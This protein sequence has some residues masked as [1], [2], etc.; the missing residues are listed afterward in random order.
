EGPVVGLIRRLRR[1][2]DRRIPGSSRLDPLAD[3]G[4][5][6]RA[7]RLLR[8]HLLRGDLSKEE[9][10]GRV[11]GPPGRPR[12]AATQ[13]TLAPGQ[14]K[15]AR[16]I[17]ATVA[18]NTNREDRTNALRDRARALRRLASAP[19]REKHAGAREHA[20]R[21][22]EPLSSHRGNPDGVYQ[23]ISSISSVL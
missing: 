20:D 21:T 13:R 10:A 11:A 2:R 9:A 8:R 5:L 15:L 4:N 18:R 1:R 16:G 19:G 17:F 23:T 3:E 22:R 14:I 12:L 6:I 7:E